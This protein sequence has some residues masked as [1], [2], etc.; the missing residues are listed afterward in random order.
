MQ[1]V[2]KKR[3][4]LEGKARR[5]KYAGVAGAVVAVLAALFSA[6]AFHRSTEIRAEAAATPLKA[7][8]PTITITPAR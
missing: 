8:P 4:D 2:T 5:W 1:D 3:A 7:D 6:F